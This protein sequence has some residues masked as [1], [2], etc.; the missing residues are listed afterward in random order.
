L[1]E[2]FFMF[3]DLFYRSGRAHSHIELGGAGIERPNLV[4]FQLKDKRILINLARGE[5]RLAEDR[6]MIIPDP[7]SFCQNGNGT[8][9]V[10]NVDYRN[11]LVFCYT[12]AGNMV[13]FSCP[14]RE[15]FSTVL[16]LWECESKRYGL[17]GVCPEIDKI[18]CIEEYANWIQCSDGRVPMRARPVGLPKV[19]GWINQML[20]IGNTSHVTGSI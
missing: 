14:T 16:L 3:S 11:T 8:N 9:A 2:H 5:R 1:V 20:S 12:K 15:L 18:G 19:S 4:Q 17:R 10:R 6:H 13:R 7:A